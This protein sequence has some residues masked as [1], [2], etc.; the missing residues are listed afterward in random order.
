MKK[1]KRK[2][3]KNS[4]LALASFVTNQTRKKN[5]LINEITN[6]KIDNNYAKSAEICIRLSANKQLSSS[7]L[8]FLVKK[9][10]KETSII[11]TA[12]C[13][14]MLISNVQ[15]AQLVF[16]HNCLFISLLAH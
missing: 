1:R 9:K 7:A 3:S 2:K 8:N 15:I 12:Y 11:P 16:W 4:N 13:T 5:K 6:K 14:G 10:E